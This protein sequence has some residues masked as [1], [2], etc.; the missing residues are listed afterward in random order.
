MVKTLHATTALIGTIIGAGIFGIPFVVMKSGFL[1]GIIH[2]LI[3]AIIISITMLY[4]G[5][6]A[7][8]TKGNFHLT[9]YAEKYLGQKGKIVM[10]LSLIFGIYTAALA[11]LI[12]VS[13]SLSYLIFS[14]S[15]YSL[16]LGIGFWILMSIISCFG[17]KALDQGEFIG[18]ITILIMIFSI[19]LLFIPKINIENL[20]ALPSISILEYFVPFG[21]ILFAFLGYTTIPEVEKILGKNKKEMRRAILLA[22]FICTIVYILFPAV[23]VGIKGADTPEI[24]TIALGKPFILLGIFTMLTSYLALSVAM[25][26]ILRFDFNRSKTKAWLYTIIVPIILFIFLTITKLA[27]FTKVLGIGGVISG[28]VA[29]VLIILMVN[30]AK[31]LGDRK[32]EFSLPTSK[33]LN[34]ILIIIL[35]IGT[36]AELI[37]ALSS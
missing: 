7:L 24:A 4:L 3:I 17:L 8:R 33:I 31:F 6:V 11:Y 13:E 30:K 2:T 21:V 23:V 15:E 27:N 29:T 16:I 35:S 22:I 32:P 12:G 10:L 34:W 37:N 9:G 28:G 18:V 25:I 19:V 1:I 14:S 5:E 36:I 26:D 20:T